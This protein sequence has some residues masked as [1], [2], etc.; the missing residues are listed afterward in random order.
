M[1]LK[2][3]L[4]RHSCFGSAQH[5]DTLSRKTEQSQRVKVGML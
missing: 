5:E 4:P 2:V 1:V 3:L